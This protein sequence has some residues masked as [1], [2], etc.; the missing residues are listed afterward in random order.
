MF[1][2]VI[3]FKTVKIPRMHDWRTNG[4]NPQNDRI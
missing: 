1:I 4:L 2:M 3:F